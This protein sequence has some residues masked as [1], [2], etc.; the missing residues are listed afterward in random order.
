MSKVL[1]LGTLTSNGLCKVLE[2]H[3]LVHSQSRPVLLF[4]RK[5]L[6]LPVSLF[7]A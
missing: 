7:A 2:K 5:K 6:R 4:C 1:L 3:S